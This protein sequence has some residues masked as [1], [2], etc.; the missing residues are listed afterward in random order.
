MKDIS[1][2]SVKKKIVTTFFIDQALMMFAGW[3]K[4]SRETN[5]QKE[6]QNILMDGVNKYDGTDVKTGHAW[7]ER[8]VDT[9]PYISISL[10]LY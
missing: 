8:T 7:N 5:T 10:Y 4:I 9:I 3:D 2:S 6:Y 1:Y